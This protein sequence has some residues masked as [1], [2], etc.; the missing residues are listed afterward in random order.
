MLLH[1]AAPFPLHTADILDDVSYA[2]I[3]LDRDWRMQY[4]NREAGRINQKPPG[5]FVGK[6]PLG[7]RPYRNLAYSVFKHGL[8]HF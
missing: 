5:K 3:A 1:R 4:A 8:S 7:P 2:I 6:V